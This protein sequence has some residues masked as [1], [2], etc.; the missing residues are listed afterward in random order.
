MGGPPEMA[1][2]LPMPRLSSEHAELLKPKP[3]DGQ[4]LTPPELHLQFASE[5]ADP[6]WSLTMEQTLRQFIAQG[7]ASG[8]FDLLNVECRSTLCEI[9]AFGNL[10]ASGQRWNSLLAEMGSQPWWSQFQGNSTSTSGTNGRTTIVSILQRA[11]R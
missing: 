10:P 1:P 7:N 11:R 8:E 5:R 3:R 2:P 6:N 9:T 4:P